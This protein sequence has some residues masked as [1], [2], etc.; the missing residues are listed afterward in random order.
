MAV[1]AGS[2]FIGNFV[3]LFLL[4]I[5]MNIRIPNIIV[6][7]GIE[8]PR[9]RAKSAFDEESE[10]DDEVAGFALLSVRVAVIT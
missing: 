8:I 1:G 10:D 7:R 5:V 9:T 6:T 3:E 2:D 4:F